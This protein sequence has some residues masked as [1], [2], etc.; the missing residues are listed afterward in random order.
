MSQSPVA[1]HEHE[2]DVDG[3]PREQDFP[4]PEGEPVLVAGL[5]LR[6]LSPVSAARGRKFDFL[7]NDN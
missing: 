2:D 7:F 1:G 6:R 5:R 4:L 3:D